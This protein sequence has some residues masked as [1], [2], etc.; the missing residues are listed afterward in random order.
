MPIATTLFGILAGHILRTRKSPQEKTAWMFVMGNALMFSGAVMNLWL[1][2]NKSLWTSSYSVFMAGLAANVF[3][4]CYW[5]IDVKGYRKWSQP[6]RIF[7]MNAIAIFALSGLL[8]KTALLV[9]IS[10]PEGS[11]QSAWG[12]VFQHLFAPL[13]SP[14]NAS[15]LFA[16]T[17]VLLF[18]GLA[19]AM[20]R[21][22]WF[23]KF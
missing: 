9:K 18:F 2:I 17:Y 8:G 15:L 21:L 10:G 3:A 20:Y 1:P 23:I 22:K 14:I 13:A 11:K 16:L 6:F 19:Y 12:Y 4:F 5:I 7:G